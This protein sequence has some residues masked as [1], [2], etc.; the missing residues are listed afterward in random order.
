LDLGKGTIPRAALYSRHGIG[1][2]RC[3]INLQIFYQLVAYEARASASPWCAKRQADG[4]E[5]RPEVG[6]QS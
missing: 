5:C 1:I 4:W 6:A 3:T 2:G